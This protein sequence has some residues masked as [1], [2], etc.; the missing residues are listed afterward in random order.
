[1]KEELIAEAL[2]S[3]AQALR[4]L[5]NG[6]A[7]TDMGGLEALGKVFDEHLPQLEPD[8]SPVERGL[9]TIAAA[10]DRHTEAV[11]SVATHLDQIAELYAQAQE[12][13]K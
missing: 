2:L 3:V 4:D 7:A 8:F 1:M 13:G 11:R 9:E 6:N 10:L 5:G 12:E